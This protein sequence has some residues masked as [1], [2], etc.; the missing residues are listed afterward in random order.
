MKLIQRT[1]LHTL[2]W[3]IPV[4]LIGSVF[5]FYMIEY[6]AHE[7][8]DEFLTYEKVRLMEYYDANQSLPDFHKVADLYE[9]DKPIQ[10]YFRDTLLLEP[11]DN[12][13][14]PHRELHFTLQHK[15]KYFHIVLRH[16]MLGSDDILE[17]TIMIVA[18]VMLLM[19]IVIALIL[20]NITGRIWR[21]FY[22]TITQ[23]N[24]HQ[25]Q[26]PV[27]TF[28]S[29][30]IDEFESL[31]KS[32]TDILGKI[33][34][35]FT[36]HREFTENTSHEL[37]THLALIRNNTE[38][39]INQIEDKN[40]EE[41]AHLQKIYTA[42]NDLT[43]AQKSLNLLTK[44]SNH[45]FQ[46]NE[47][48]DFKETI[49]QSLDK[50]DEMVKMRSIRVDKKLAQSTH[51]IDKGLADILINNLLKNAVKHNIE[52]GFIEIELKPNVLVITNSG[53]S[54]QKNPDELMNRFTKGRDG[55]MGIG[56]SIVK[57]ICDR[58]QYKI[59]YTISPNKIH[60]TEIHFS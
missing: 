40:P 35:D 17:G 36:N 44:I 27:P 57:Q 3:L 58:Y 20:R 32:L 53:Q 28:S 15:D 29:G 16:L 50:F 31:N 52:G 26:Q 9:T 34:R 4:M 49:V 51:D 46:Q 55:N 54:F 38:A 24:Q 42:V 2:K 14:V 13:L 41:V 45:E 48:I 60:R 39:L 23:L 37:Q 33:E 43:Q 11:L 5:C 47:S 25:L 21:P 10:T 56:L 19:A 12:E 22:N 18:G 1:Y 7:E 6:I 30:G 59:T 8:T